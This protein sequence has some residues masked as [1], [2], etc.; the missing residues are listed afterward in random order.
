LK[1][2]N[3]TAFWDLQLRSLESLCNLR[4]A[5]AAEAAGDSVMSG[6]VSASRVEGPS[7]VHDLTARLAQ[8]AAE[9]LYSFPRLLFSTAISILTHHTL[10]H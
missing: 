2:A 9:R 8:D 10:A 7:A 4:E 5:L 1:L 6:I 3:L